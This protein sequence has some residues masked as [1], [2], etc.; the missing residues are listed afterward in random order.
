MGKKYFFLVIVL[1]AAFTGFAQNNNSYKNGTSYLNSM[2]NGTAIKNSFISADGN[3]VWVC[4]ELGTLKKITR[5]STSSIPE[6]IPQST[7][8]NDVYFKP[9]GMEGCA[10]TGNGIVYCTAD[11]GISWREVKT[12]AR[13]ALNGIDFNSD[14][15]TG[16]I[17]GD[18]GTVLL[19]NTFAIDTYTT[20]NFKY[21]DDLNGCISGKNFLLVYSKSKVY[22]SKDEGKN[23]E[24]LELNNFNKDFAASAIIDIKYNSSQYQCVIA[25][26]S[27]LFFKLDLF[28]NAVS[29][30]NFPSGFKNI[31]AIALTQSNE[32]Y[33]LNEGY[34]LYK[35]G[36]SSQPLFIKN[37]YINDMLP[38]N[39]LRME[40][41][42]TGEVLSLVG[43]NNSIAI[44]FNIS[45]NTWVKDKAHPYFNYT[46]TWYEKESKT[47]YLVGTNGLFMR[48]TI[49]ENQVQNIA[50]LN[51]KGYKT[52]FTD[53]TCYNGVYYLT[54]DSLSI[55][56][57]NN[58]TPLKRVFK[59]ESGS[60]FN[61]ITCANN[62]IIAVGNNSAVY[63]KT[64]GSN[65]WDFIYSF[66]G[67]E[68]DFTKV[69]VNNNQIYLIG[70]HNVI[71]SQ[72]V[73]SNL[74]DTWK[75]TSLPNVHKSETFADIDFASDNKMGFLISSGMCSNNLFITQDGGISWNLASN[76]SGDMTDINHVR[77]DD[78]NKFLYLTS[79]SG[80]IHKSNNLGKSF[81]KVTP[82]KTTN[83][84][85]DISFDDKG[86]PIFAGDNGT[87]LHCSQMT[88]F[89]ISGLNFQLYDGKFIPDVKIENPLNKIT[90]KFEIRIAYFTPDKSKLIA[91]NTIA[92]EEFGKQIDYPEVVKN[93]YDKVNIE[94]SMFDG[95]TL[96]SKDTV[97]KIGLSLFQQLARKMYWVPTEKQ[98]S[99]SDAITNNLVFAGFLYAAFVLFLFIISPIRFV[100]LHEAIAS[101]RLPFP[102]KISK[103]LL[104]Y[105]ITSNRC[106]NAFTKYYR[107][108]AL[109]LYNSNAEV[110]SR[111]HWVVAPLKIN[112]RKFTSFYSDKP[113]YIPG[114]HEIKQLGNKGRFIISIIGQGGSGKSSFALQLMRWAYNDND[115]R[116]LFSSPALPIFINHLDVSLDKKIRLK[117]EYITG[118]ANLSDTLVKALLNKKRIITVVDG[119]SEMTDFKNEFIDPELGAKDAYAVIFTSRKPL[120]FS[121]INTVT[122]LG[123]DLN[124]LDSLIERFTTTFVGIE[125]FGSHR[126]TLRTKIKQMMVEMGDQYHFK[127]I[128]LILLKLIIDRA[129][130]LVE[131]EGNLEKLPKNINGLMDDYIHALLANT[132]NGN[133]LV[134]ELR[135]AALISLGLSEVLKPGFTRV[136]NKQAFKPAWI[137]E[138]IFKKHI[139]QADLNYLINS[140][141]LQTE[142]ELGD[143]TIKFAYD[144]LSEYL[145]A[146]ELCI[147]YR[148]TALPEKVIQDLLTDCCIQNDPLYKLV[149]NLSKHV[150]IKLAYA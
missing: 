111:Q 79:A 12:P 45:N 102:E 52:N 53:I 49:D 118:N 139:D 78:R 10:L 7:T 2:Y 68:E 17:C 142:G 86:Y 75:E 29:R 6:N 98:F 128:P 62:N 144:T 8:I 125:H 70:A 31:S 73:K 100:F 69:I 28:T 23:F 96:T 54:G 90:N 126:E 107:A 120:N 132:E 9:D 63:Y 51:P 147:Y 38:A 36:N 26:K 134:K 92:F 5:G 67:K 130:A 112:V 34:Q 109:D 133:H 124:S 82:L 47:L 85:R 148:D 87:L 140:G 101:S 105:L 19:S 50:N 72:P 25:L 114:L 66:R 13:T 48:C 103:F 95:W 76:F 14:K 65:E 149:D 136:T 61:S 4:G 35:L 1:F 39:F 77:Y 104:F 117:L 21:D 27:G 41:S 60:T 150:G 71:Y 59:G 64:A 119:I 32:L 40:C 55:Y 106:V 46:K 97:V 146:K 113:D 91:E 43:K 131:K 108:R 18:K 80:N 88:D 16:L 145:T 33:F 121:D 138:D 24:P 37:F 110:Q 141:I 84:I 129:A 58:E 123:L 30:I 93:N 42:A 135:K 20:V 44:T 57:F 127:A 74:N 81:Y 3:A 122:P 15:K 143:K 56:T 115:K 94:I 83:N 89:K 11:G 116:M 137:S 99:W 22:L